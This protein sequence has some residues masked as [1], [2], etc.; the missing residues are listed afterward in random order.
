M[1]LLSIEAETKRTENVVRVFDVRQK[2]KGLPRDGDDLKYVA[3]EEVT[4]SRW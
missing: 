3:L 4:Q 1:L 2:L